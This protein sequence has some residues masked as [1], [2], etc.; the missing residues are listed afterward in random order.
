[1]KI[2]PFSSTA[3]QISSASA[4]LMAMGF[5]RKTCF[6][7]LAA[8]TAMEQCMSVRVQMETASTPLSARSLS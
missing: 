5:S 2:T 8:A 1:M 3:R 7:A 6:P 4:A